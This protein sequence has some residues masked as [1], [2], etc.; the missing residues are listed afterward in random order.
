LDREQQQIVSDFNFIVSGSFIESAGCALIS[1]KEA[2]SQAQPLEIGGGKLIKSFWLIS[3][4][5]L[6]QSPA[7]TMA[8]A[9]VAYSPTILRERQGLIKL[10]PTN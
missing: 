6:K 1:H 9:S 7:F 10:L 3:T 2:G 5:V 4:L 8:N